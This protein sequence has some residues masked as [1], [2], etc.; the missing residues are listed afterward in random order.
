M[1]SAGSSASISATQTANG[2][3][4]V[5]GVLTD[6]SFWEYD[7]QFAGSHFQELLASGAALGSAPQIR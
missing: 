3:D 2:N 4:A 6:T 5:F 7:P 1:L